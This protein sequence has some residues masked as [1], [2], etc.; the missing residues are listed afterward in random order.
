MKSVGVGGK[1]SVPVLLSILALLV[2]T[3]NVH[4]QI[5]SERT[6][7]RPVS[8]KGT[9]IIPDKF[10]RNYDPVTIF[11]SSAVGSQKGPEL[12]P[13]KFVNVEPSHPGLFFWL[14]ASTLQFRPA[15]PWPPFSEF[16]W[17]AGNRKISLKSLLE[18]PLWTIPEDGSSNMNSI[19]TI[20]LAFASVI[21]ESFL[22]DFLTIEIRDLP[23]L[24]EG[25]GVILDKKDF[26]VK[27]LE[28]KN[29]KDQAVYLVSLN[30]PISE[31]KRVI[32]HLKLSVDDQVDS[33]KQI[34]FTT[35][36]Y[37]RILTAGSRTTRYPMSLDGS[38]YGAGQAINMGNEKTL[39]IEFSSE[40]EG[41]GPVTGRNL[42]NLE[43][44]VDDLTF[45]MKGKLLEITGDFQI[46]QTYLAKIQPGD[47]KD[48]NGHS[49][50]QKNGHTFYFYFPSST[51][52]LKWTKGNGICERYGPQNVPVQGRGDERADLRIFKIDPLDRSFWPF[53]EIPI[54]LDESKRHPAPEEEPDAYSQPRYIY[55]Y[56]LK[57]QLAAMGSPPVSE[58][59]TLPLKKTKGAANFG[60]DVSNHLKKI[61]GNNAPGTY[62][63]GIRRLEDKGKRSWIRIQVTDLSLTTV[64]N[65]NEVKFVVT[66]LRTGQPVPNTTI[67]VEG[68]KKRKWT[69]VT[70]G[71]T[72][73]DGIYTWKVKGN[74][75]YWIRRISLRNGNDYLVLNPETKG[76][77][78]HDNQWNES[79]D[80]WL[81]WTQY[82]IR[83]RGEIATTIAHIFTERPVYRPEEKV[84]IKGYLR[85][86]FQGVLSPKNT[87]GF[88]NIYGPGD[89]VWRY[90]VT[91]N[92]FGSFY[93]VFE[94]PN[95][96]AGE[97]SANFEMKNGQY[98][99]YVRWRMEAYRIPKFEVK[100]HGDTIQ[101]MDEP[102]K[103]SLTA[104]Y[105]AGGKVSESK[106]NWK[107]TQ[108]PLDWTRD[109]PSGFRYATDGRYSGM[110]EFEAIPAMEFTAETD[111]NGFAEIELDPT[112]EQTIR[113]RIYVIEATVEGAD[114]QT[115]T[116]V[117]RVKTVPT[118]IL[119][120]KLP[121]FLEQ[122]EKITPEIIAAGADGSMKSGVPITVKLI[123]RQWH[124][125]L[126][127]G[128][129]SSGIA[130]YITDVVDEKIRELQIIS[131]EE[132]V[133]IDLM[134]PGAGVY[135]VELESHDKIGRAQVVS[136]DLF[137][138]GSEPLTWSKPINDVF[139][140]VLDKKSYEPGDEA[141]CVLESPFQTGMVLAV[142]EAPDQNYYEWTPIRKGKGTFTIPIKK[143][144]A[145][146]IPVHFILMR[147]R[148]E[149]IKPI[150]GS[151]EDL[152]KPTTM[153]CTSWLKVNPSEN[154]LDLDLKYPEQVEPGTEVDIQIKLSTPNHEPVEGEVTL[155]LVDQAILALGKEQSLDPLP[156]F[157]VPAN[158]YVDVRDTRNSIFGNIVYS[159]LPGGGE[160]EY[161]ASLLDRVTVRKNFQPVPY[162]N[163]SILTDKNGSAVIKVKM[164]D[165]LTNFAIRA[166][167]VNKKDR[168][169]FKIG[170]ISVRL[171][172]VIQPVLPRFVRPGD[173]FLGGGIGRVIEGDI[174]AGRAEINIQ[175]GKIEG[176]TQ[177]NFSWTDS[178][179]EKLLYPIRIADTE[180]DP[181][182]PNIENQV[183]F[184]LAV[185][186]IVDQAGDAFKIS[187]PVKREQRMI[188]RRKI[189]ELGP[190][191][192]YT[193][194]KVEDASE[195]KGFYTS[196]LTATRP[197]LLKMASGL[198]LL[199]EY[200]YGCTEQRLS[201]VRS[202]L[203]MKSLNDDF[204]LGYDE[205]KMDEVVRDFI[206]YIPSI[207]NEKNMCRY[208]PGSDGY[209]SLTAWVF[210]LLTDASRQGY[211]VDQQLYE[212]LAVTLDKSLRS[213]FRGFINGGEF[214]E[215]C[216]ALIA[217]ADA[218][219][220]RPAFASELAR[221]TQFLKL[222]NA[223]QVVRVLSDCPG[224][225]DEMVQ[226]LTGDLWKRIVTKL[227]NGK[228][229]YGGIKDES[230][231][232][233]PLILPSEVRSLAELL[234]TMGQVDSDDQRVA[235]L[236]NALVELGG[237]DGWGS[238]N[239]NSSAIE[240]LSRAGRITGATSQCS[241]DI[242]SGSVKKTLKMGGDRPISMLNLI[243]NDKLKLKASKRNAGSICV[244][245]DT[246][247]YP[248]KSGS[249]SAAESNGF[250]I[251]REIKRLRTGLTAI[252]SP[253]DVPGK[254]V[255]VN[256]GDLIEE[257]IQIVNPENRHFVAVI[258]P[259]AAGVEPMNP[260]LETSSSEAR[261]TGQSTVTASYTSF[262]D[263]YIGYYFD[264]LP[265]GNYD[266]YFRCRA[267]VEGSF[268][269]PAAWVELMYN[270]SIF[271][272]SN[273]ASI[274]VGES[275]ETP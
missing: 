165:N 139:N 113:P 185:E 182:N 116:A 257:H 112:Q 83:Y 202:W 231:S 260:N 119:G 164:S 265:K 127:A 61:S 53:P 130:R 123:R 10:L 158:T 249:K 210:Q 159:E 99:G 25:S 57:A 142:I 71:I 97:Y 80:N 144:Y 254:V 191:D 30:A 207:L 38:Q 137:A 133:K 269:Q 205:E 263:D 226:N 264:T 219:R 229:V 253:L 167:A 256:K 148:V 247:Y 20:T 228:E 16:L 87:N 115:V 136:V 268:T 65:S 270:Q 59:I 109:L 89:L 140:T 14:D 64:E 238:T 63:L 236:T 166:K 111:E 237:A 44:P 171:P 252:M 37:F 7:L 274:A 72:G 48:R 169:G 45:T 78:F 106:I 22:Q 108:F 223:A 163:P 67:S 161:D 235:M 266:F 225:P 213:D 154:L 15:D 216:W 255:E 96:P 189:M 138:G 135:I 128:D 192:D 220:M 46:G 149:N 145:P 141:N 198:N 243:Q 177:R 160:G 11:F 175:G 23:G 195:S 52:Y 85:S 125:H 153:A 120:I 230:A 58:I 242:K 248:D 176:N 186:R 224:T 245:I 39:I 162:Y 21:P 35:A 234:S 150:P 118:V 75:K 143:Q 151:T 70:S 190:G 132:P 98:V 49:M 155:W 27:I 101:S 2:L 12:H 81:Q 241:L 84:H 194:K 102:F 28:R 244:R 95:L 250:V 273:G 183:S 197:D 68:T 240:A 156:D 232:L 92:D 272:S 258:I 152:G 54:F 19:Q 168:F 73:K 147:G 100:L 110:P 51:S 129:F 212:N 3:V 82:D 5:A 196:L 66:S 88:L 184:T 209:I 29:R 206:D 246:A 24:G 91:G 9:V 267:S 201:L 172:V 124:S 199:L 56:E 103:I 114:D 18:A 157:M 42:L 208:W 174:G 134:L 126:R 188:H 239:A 121:R 6:T 180:L 55:N 122:S 107:V 146:R 41:I 178:K 233:N 94:E 221:K 214:A 173:K 215:Q 4:G 40:P 117:H 86:R 26:S 259:I 179:I 204:A 36:E 17:S 105:Y 217:L 193:G 1:W 222:E 60:I 211:Y 187:I 31:G 74:D 200:P 8:G 69:T 77:V 33:F 93:T 181:G 262:M 104:D 251:S 271:G 34:T 275:S 50:V 43:P 76:E 13:E 79:Y 90:P 227:Q 32:V 131:A 170:K 203:A 261:P 218:G 62:L 47:I